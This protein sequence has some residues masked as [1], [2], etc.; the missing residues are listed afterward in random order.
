[1]MMML[2]PSPIHEPVRAQVMERRLELDDVD[3]LV[4]QEMTRLSFTDREKVL[5]DLHAIADNHFDNEPSPKI[6]TE[7]L[8]EFQ[9]ALDFQI[10]AD[11]KI[12]YNYA[13]HTHPNFVQKEAFRI[14]FL[15]TDL[16]DPYKAAIRF[17]KHFQ[18]K[19]QLF[20]RELLGEEIT[21]DDL[22]PGTLE[23]LYGGFIQDLPLRDMAG[24]VISFVIPNPNEGTILHKVCVGRRWKHSI[25]LV[26][27]VNL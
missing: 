13:C 16:W 25:S 7:R 11:Q 5:Q 1:M 4:A 19:Q 15:R 10:P 14:Q 2:L 27:V 20:G 12:D 21:Q 8:Q 24:R 17:V 23:I 18:V 22:D 9:H 6:R 3:T 26:V